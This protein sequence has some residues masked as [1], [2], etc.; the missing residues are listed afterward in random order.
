LFFFF[1][2][3]LSLPLALVA[4]SHTSLSSFLSLSR[5]PTL[6]AYLHLHCNWL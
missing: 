6:Q 1:S 3:A 4:P 5:T 2:R